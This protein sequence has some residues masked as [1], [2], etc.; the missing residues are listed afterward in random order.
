M[1]LRFPSVAPRHSR[2]AQQF[3]APQVSG[4]PVVHK[5]VV[6]HGY[7][8][9]HRRKTQLHTCGALGFGAPRV[10]DLPVAHQALVRHRYASCHYLPS[11]PLFHLTHFSHSSPLHV[12][13]IWSCSSSSLPHF[14][15]R[16]AHFS[17]QNLLRLIDLHR[18]ILNHLGSRLGN[19]PTRITPPLRLMSVTCQLVGG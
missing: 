1:K 19:L 6:R 12:R 9:G 10:F 8:W 17:F 5:I 15:Y 7:V 13:Q 4:L 14:L 3:G 11:L 16:L 18:D 2:G